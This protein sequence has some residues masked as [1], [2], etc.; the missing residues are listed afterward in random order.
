MKPQPPLTWFSTRKNRNRKTFN[1]AWG[2]SPDLDSW[3]LL[4]W[5][6]TCQEFCLFDRLGELFAYYRDKLPGDFDA[7]VTT[8]AADS[9]ECLHCPDHLVDKVR[10]IVVT[11]QGHFAKTYYV[12]AHNG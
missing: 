7:G 9:G 8:P 12:G 11:A 4:M 2:V 3:D 6:R 5:Q 1:V 10:D